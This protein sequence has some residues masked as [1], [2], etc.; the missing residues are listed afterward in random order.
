M[1]CD[2]E[3]RAMNVADAVSEITERLLFLRARPCRV[4]QGFRAKVGKHYLLI[5]VPGGLNFFEE[6]G[7]H[8]TSQGSKWP[9]QSFLLHYQL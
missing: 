1:M 3:I 8:R 6:T 7:S 2:G 9:G 5:F 4:A